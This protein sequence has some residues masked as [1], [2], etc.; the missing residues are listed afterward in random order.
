MAIADNHAGTYRRVRLDPV[1]PAASG[2]IEH[3]HIGLFAVTDAYRSL[4]DQ[5]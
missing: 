3:Q 1:L 2:Q 5:G 4:V